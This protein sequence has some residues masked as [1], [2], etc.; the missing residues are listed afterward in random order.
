MPDPEP[1]VNWYRVLTFLSF[2]ASSLLALE[3]IPAE[4]KP[5]LVIA[6]IV[7]SGALTIFFGT[8]TNP[9]VVSRVVK[10]FK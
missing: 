1:V 5:Y 9:S 2:I 6:L 8:V 7:I 4:I 3:M 10:R